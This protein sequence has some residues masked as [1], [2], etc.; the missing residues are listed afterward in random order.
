MAGYTSTKL[1]WLKRSRRRLAKV[2]HLA[3]PHDYL[4]QALTG[5]LVMEGGDAWD[6]L[7]TTSSARDAAAAAAVD[8]DLLDKLRRSSGPQ[9]TSGRA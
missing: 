2:R 1:L 6:G 7:S 9:T 5:T 4:H 8:E 3:L